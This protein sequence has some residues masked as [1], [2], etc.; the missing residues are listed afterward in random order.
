MFADLQSAE[1]R[2]MP[3]FLL[4]V[5]L[6]RCHS[7]E[8][9]SALWGFIVGEASGDHRKRQGGVKL[10][11]GMSP[12]MSGIRLLLRWSTSLSASSVDVSRCVSKIY[13]P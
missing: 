7:I 5:L 3:A 13:L 2:N 9:M 8:V 4:G 11:S 12:V 6:K 10:S 1:C